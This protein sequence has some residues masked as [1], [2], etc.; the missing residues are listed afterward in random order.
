MR[1][2]WFLIAAL[3]FIEACTNSAKNLNSQS[4]IN[5]DN[6]VPSSKTSPL[7]AIVPS[8][9]NLF[10][11]NLNSLHY[12]KWNLNQLPDSPFMQLKKPENWL[13]L[14][15]PAFPFFAQQVIAGPSGNFFVFDKLGKRICQYDTDAQLLSCLELP[16]EVRNL[17]LEDLRI[18]WS[19]S[20][21]AFLHYAQGLV[22]QY[23]LF[24][25][26]TQNEE[27]QL[28][29]TLKI[30][31]GLSQCFYLK[32]EHLYRCTRGDKAIDFDFYFNVKAETGLNTISAIQDLHYALDTQAWYFVY[33]GIHAMT[34]KHTQLC[35]YPESK[36]LI[37]CATP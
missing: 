10:L 29:N 34:Q 8:R 18:Y 36:N 23:S 2:K 33:K 17:N 30:P 6:S 35:F 26:S 1:K 15:T 19:E 12:Q 37:P 24:Q 31:L 11:F 5:S 16:K 21:M 4:T 32:D 9:N 14:A 22:W 7:Q 3:I 27:W 25:T 20:G 13:A 28:R